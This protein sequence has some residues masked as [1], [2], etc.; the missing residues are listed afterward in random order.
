MLALRLKGRAWEPEVKADFSRLYCTYA[1]KGE[2]DA[3]GAT[4]AS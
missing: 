4:G 3:M 2:T 1:P